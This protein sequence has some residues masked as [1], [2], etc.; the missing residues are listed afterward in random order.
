MGDS[1]AGA[2]A[3]A[4]MISIVTCHF[5]HYRVLTAFKLRVPEEIL[6]PVGGAVTAVSHHPSVKPLSE[7][8]AGQKSPAR[9][10]GH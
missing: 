6:N 9:S 10:F 7:F 3:Q 4:E 2:V 1:G 5:S 8:T